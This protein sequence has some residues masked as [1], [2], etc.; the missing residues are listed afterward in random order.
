MIA[1][2][3]NIENNGQKNFG[4]FADDLLGRTFIL[5]QIFVRTFIKINILCQAGSPSTQGFPLPRLL[6][7][8]SDCYLGRYP[9]QKTLPKKQGKFLLNLL[10]ITYFYHCDVTILDE[11]RFYCY[12]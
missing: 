4:T 1:N 5:A 7:R 8:Q 12:N 2:N 9:W 3:K 6:V 10:K 11:K